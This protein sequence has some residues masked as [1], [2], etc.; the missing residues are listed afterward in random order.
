MRHV[1]PLI[2]AAA[3]FLGISGAAAT[4]ADT[5]APPT[6]N[7]KAQMTFFVGTYTGPKSKGIYQFRLDPA[8]GTIT[9]GQLAGE[10]VNP[11]FVALHPSGKY[12]YAVSEAGGRGAKSGIVAA[13]AIDPQ[14]SFLTRLNEQ[15]SGGQ[16]PCHVSVDPSGR[17]ALVA[18]YSGGTA[19][20]IPIGPDGKLGDPTA[21]VKHEGKSINPKRQ[22]KPYTHSIN[23]DP[24]GRFAIVADLGID[25][26]MVYRL[27]AAKGTLTPNDPPFATV[28]AGSGPRHLAFHPT[29]RYAYVI[30]EMG[31]TITAF[32]YDADRGALAE[33]GSVPTLPKDFTGPNTTAEVVAHPNG[34]FLYGSN[35]GHNSIARFTVDPATG[36]L[37]PTGHTPSGGKTPRNF[38]IDPTGTIL[39]AAHQDTHNLVVFRIDAAT[40]DLTPTGSTAEIGS[41]VCIRF[42]PSAK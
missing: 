16:G 5:A 38:V 24:A 7:A 35:R 12:L 34:K 28:T 30:N 32:T 25:K 36:K 31:N 11:S 14:T 26:L 18:N 33:I 6:L 9:P 23:T 39:I 15:S 29:G 22:D 17:V 19:S 20:A 40:G 42:L 10:A 8:A 1:F 21:V 13:F 27:D 41:P 4:A 3:A 37:T 2:C